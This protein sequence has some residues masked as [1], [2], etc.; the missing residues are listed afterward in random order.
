[1]EE[2]HLTSLHGLRDRRPQGEAF[3]QRETYWACDCR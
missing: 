1:M 3:L 2:S